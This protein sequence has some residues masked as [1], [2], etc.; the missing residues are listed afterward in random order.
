MRWTIRRKLFGLTICAL[1]FVAAVSVNGYWAI[2][3]VAKTTSE[4]A[5]TGSAIRN[6]IEA[7]VYNDLTR[8]DVSGA[9]T[10]KGDDQQNKADDF[11]QHC[12]LLEDRIAKAREFAADPASH[13]MLDEEQQVVGEYVKAGNSLVNAIVHQP[14]AAPPLLGPYLQLYKDLQ[15]KIEITSDQLSNGA[16]AAELKAEGN[17]TKATRATLIIC[18]ASLFLLLV[19]AT[20]VTFGITRPLDAFSTQFEAMTK[21]NDLT[22]RV[23]ETRGDEI[24]QLGKCLNQ[25]VEKVQEI[26]VPIAKTADGM[27]TA[28]EDLSTNSHRIE[29]NSEKTTEQARA[30]SVAGGQVNTNLQTLASGAD[31]MN[32]TIAEIARN[33]TDAARISGE[34]VAAAESANQTVTKLGDSSV[35]IEKVIEVITSIA[36]QT[37]LLALNATIEAA[38]AGEAG[39]GFAVVANEVKELAK[40]TA[41]ATEDIKQKISIIR[42][43]TSGAVTAIGGIKGVIDKVS[44]IST[45]IAT[46]VEEQS[47][48]TSEMTRNVNEAAR[49]A[50]TISDNIQGVADAAQNT[51]TAVSEA[52]A[53]TEGLAEMASNLRELVGRFKVGD[54]IT[55]SAATETDPVTRRAAAGS[56]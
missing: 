49:G 42:E 17:A 2:S 23:D 31:E 8:A 28:S 51:S 22:A 18:A 29:A 40:Q 19:I 13:A 34:A 21:A 39:K 27:A 56:N 48:T 44:H 24:G 7:G 20:K 33:A 38:R 35:E 36:Q 32:S 12:K 14:G 37:N 1:A 52:K 16:K 45:V 46:A 53:A 11:A 47:A 25:F 10:A 41:R 54:T 15:G 9:F 4:V 55:M 26:L 5:A 43:N 30:A 6:H 3:S 50:G